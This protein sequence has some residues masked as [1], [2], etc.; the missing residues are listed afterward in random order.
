MSIK[1]AHVSDIHVRKLTY[2]KEYRVVFERLYEKLREIK[3][4]II[5][6]TGDTF[7][8]KL[9]MSPEEPALREIFKCYRSCRG[10][11]FTRPI[12][13]RSGKLAEDATV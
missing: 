10:R 11:G 2:H 8:T 4:D 1:I 5:I 6:N 13:C 12:D 3:P 9:D 7:H